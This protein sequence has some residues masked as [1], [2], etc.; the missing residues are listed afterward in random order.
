MTTTIPQRA[1]CERCRHPRPL[2][3]ESKGHCTAPGC[4]SGPAGGICLGFVYGGVITATGRP[5][6]R[7]EPEREGSHYAGDGCD[8]P[9]VISQEQDPGDPYQYLLQDWLLSQL[10][11]NA[12]QAEATRAHLRHGESSMLYGGD[13]RRYRI[14]GEEVGEV[15]RELNDADIDGREPDRDKLVNELIQVA[16]MACTWIEALEG[17]HRLRQIGVLPGAG[18]PAGGES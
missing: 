3:R 17:G 8:P 15:A 18:K 2:H 12:I 11:L 4:H 6:P 5:W 7:P 14:L 1:T 9:H 16:A 10:T 13:D